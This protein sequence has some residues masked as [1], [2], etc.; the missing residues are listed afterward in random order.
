MTHKVIIPEMGIVVIPL[1]LFKY[2]KLIELSCL[3]IPTNYSIK[4]EN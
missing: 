3:L 2:V 4:S 1:F